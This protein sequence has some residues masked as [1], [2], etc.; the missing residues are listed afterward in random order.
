VK[1][2]RKA[3]ADGRYIIDV[4]YRASSRHGRGLKLGIHVRDTHSGKD[5]VAFDNAHEKGTGLWPPHLHSG[6]SRRFYLASDTTSEG[7]GELLRAGV[8]I[9]CDRILEEPQL[10]EVAKTEIA[11]AL[12]AMLLQVLMKEKWA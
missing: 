1:K 9:A 7:P 6:S 12:T 5:M 2:V 11:A 8:A 3:V 10:G 4:L